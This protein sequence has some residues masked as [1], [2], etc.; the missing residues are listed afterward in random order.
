MKISIRE[1]RRT[2]EFLE[3]DAARVCPPDDLQTLTNVADYLRYVADQREEFEARQREADPRMQ[4]LR[5]ALA[6]VWSARNA[7]LAGRA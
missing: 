3:G 4:K 6:Q 1:L 7:R 2:A 5:T